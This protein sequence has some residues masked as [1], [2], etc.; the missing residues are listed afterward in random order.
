MSSGVG[1]DKGACILFVGHKIETNTPQSLS[2][3][4]VRPTAVQKQKLLMRGGDKNGIAA[5]FSETKDHALPPS[6]HA[7]VVRKQL[8]K[9]VVCFSF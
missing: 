7:S 8:R 3:S 5:S 4:V 2:L 9:H 6:P 1:R